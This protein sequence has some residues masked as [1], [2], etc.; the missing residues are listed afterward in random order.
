MAKKLRIP[1]FLIAVVP[2]LAS[3][4]HAQATDSLAEL[5]RKVEILAE[6]LERLKLGEGA[7]LPP[8]SGQGLG[9]AS[10][11]V[12]SLR[13]PG[14]SV[15][16]Y[17]E[18]LYENFSDTRDDKTA[19]GRR[20]QIDYLR[21]VMYFGYRFNDWILFNSEIEIEHASTGTGGEVSVEFGYLDLI[22]SDWITIRSGMV[23]MPLGIINE[24]HEPTTFLGTVRPYTER[25]I[26]PATWR[27]IGVGATGNLTSNLGYR[28]YLVESLDAS[29]FSSSGGIRGG[30][31][32]GSRAL[33]EDFG[34]AGRLEYSPLP[35]ASLGASLFGGKTGQGAT[36]SL[37]TVDGFTLVTSAHAELL[38]R[39]LEARALFALASI[40]Q[41][42]RISRLVNETVGSGMNG[43]YVAVGY[44]LMSEIAPTS[45]HSLLPYVQYEVFDTQSSVPSGFQT[46]PANRRKTVTFGLM[47]KPDPDVAFK[48]DFQNNWNA[49]GTAINQWNIA[50]SYIF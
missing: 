16:G 9:P 6:E 43:W 32:K 39:G 40:D 10:S 3:S 41:A 11:R 2:L 20:D 19:S 4:S 1:T 12:Y 8:L 24:K 25:Y 18:L 35:G 21:A 13:K 23:L 22:L 42:D 30:R 38:W 27:A 33:A 45:L 47:Y 17:G 29:G 14:V 15:A 26:I 31:Q 7:D 36:D 44:D 48:A 28:L 50:A 37:G 5:N 49:A 34:L 46:D